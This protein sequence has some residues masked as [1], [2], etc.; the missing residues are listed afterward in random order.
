VLR[1]KMV[2]EKQCHEKPPLLG[3]DQ[4]LAINAT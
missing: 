3:T 2:C 4:A 1:R